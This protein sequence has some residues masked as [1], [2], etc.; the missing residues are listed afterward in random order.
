MNPQRAGAGR[1]RDVPWHRNVLLICNGEPPR[2]ATL[3]RIAR[4]ADLVVAADG[5][6]NA[7]RRLGIRPEVIVGD[8]DSILPATRR[9][10][11]DSEIVRVP[12]QDNTDLEKALDLLLERRA[13]GVV[14]A[15]A[16]GGRI[17]HTLGNLS[18]IWNYSNRLTI[19]VVGEGWMA[20]PV[21]S[22]ARIDA[23]PG[24]T[25][26][27]I[28]FGVCRGVT[29]RGLHYPL[30]NATLRVGNIGVSNV[31]RRSPFSVSLRSGRLLVVAHDRWPGIRPCR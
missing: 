6:A 26:S 8:L 17:D 2:Q 14:I 4:S 23:R 29:L 12:R 24:T 1:G 22:S 7:A 10:F 27:I 11:A 25:V 13:T 28:P 16:T 21:E 18:V 15:G 30:T 31:V 9:Y 5:G 19:T 20:F 3:R